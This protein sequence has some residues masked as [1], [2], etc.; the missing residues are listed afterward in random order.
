VEP[1]ESNN[2]F[3]ELR[4]A[5]SKLKLTAFPQKNFQP[6]NRTPDQGFPGEHEGL[7]TAHISPLH[8][9]TS[10]IPHN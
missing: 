5:G 2:A 10:E 3:D 6:N 8:R 7:A 4:V 9:T 1:G